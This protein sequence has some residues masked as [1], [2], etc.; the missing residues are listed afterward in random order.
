[1][2]NKV[3]IKKTLAVFYHM[4]YLQA[5][6]TVFANPVMGTFIESLSPYF[7]KILVIGFEAVEGKENISYPIKV[8]NISFISIGPQGKFWDYFVKKKRV[9]TIL[10]TYKQ[11][12][13]YLLLRVPSHSSHLIWDSLG[14]INKTLLLFIGS[15]YFTSAYHNN[16]IFMH[17][18]RRLRSSIHDYKMKYIIKNT[19]NIIMANSPSLIELWGSKFNRNIDLVNTSSL[20]E[21][22]ILN[23]K[24]IDKTPSSTYSLLFLCRVCFD[25]GIREILSALQ[26][27]NKI[28]SDKYN[29][30]IVGPIGD[31]GGSDLNQLIND[32]QLN[33]NVKYYGSIPFGEEV[34]KFF[35]EA[36][37]YILPSYHEGMPKTIWESMSQGTPVIAS[38]IDGISGYFKNME[39]IIFVKPK[40]PESIVNAILTLF[41]SDILFKRLQLNGLKKVKNITKESQAMIIADSIHKNWVL[42]K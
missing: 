2:P 12:I 25:K 14:S 39:E 31:L 27:L 41:D 19:D 10:N 17:V 23:E 11:E 4:P 18:F 38:A 42:D 7:K 13:D 26:K 24:Y 32:Y 29:L 40:D 1:M 33:S 15:P 9:A 5:E 35:K 8:K 36:D 34:L 22:D 6:E 20:S 3:M 30:K 21:N 37:A 16:N 28:S